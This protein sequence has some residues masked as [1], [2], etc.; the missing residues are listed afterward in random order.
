VANADDYNNQTIVFQFAD[1]AIVA[2]P[3]FPI[4]AQS[5]VE[6]FTDQSRILEACDSLVEKLGDAKRHAFIQPFEFALGGR[7]EL[8]RPIL[9]G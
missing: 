6:A 1:D 9:P 8:N 3:I 5:P 2:D 4:V 7:I